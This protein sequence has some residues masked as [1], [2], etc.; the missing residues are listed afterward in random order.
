MSRSDGQSEEKTISV[1]DPKKAWYSFIDPRRGIL[2]FKVAYLWLCVMSS[3]PNAAEDQPCRGAVKSHVK[4][5]KAQSSHVG[6]A[7]K[8]RNGLPALV[9]SSSIDRSSKL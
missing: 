9:L 6:V 7:W 4:F 5:T 2:V 1:L 3:S 8:L